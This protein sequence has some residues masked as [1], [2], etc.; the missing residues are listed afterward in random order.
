MN[1]QVSSR[2][3]A[4]ENAPAQKSQLASQPKNTGPRSFGRDITNVSNHSNQH[5]SQG[6]KTSKPNKETIV[7]QEVTAKV[8]SVP[9]Q[10]V[11]PVEYATKLRKNR[12][13]TRKKVNEIADIL[14]APVSNVPGF[15]SGPLMSE[16]DQ[17]DFMSSIR[18]GETLS[19]VFSH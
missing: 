19:L 14:T 6:G 9:Q 8:L 16:A 17:D 4:G 5:K 3:H 2:Y 13:K 7:L 12:E 18:K 15:L 11:H 1:T 10:N